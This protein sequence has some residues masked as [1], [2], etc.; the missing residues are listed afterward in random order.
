MGEYADGLLAGG[1]D[2]VFVVDE[3]ELARILAVN[4]ILN[5]YLV[6]KKKMIIRERTTRNHLL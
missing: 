6:L 4:H 2:I 1:D 5:E 3:A